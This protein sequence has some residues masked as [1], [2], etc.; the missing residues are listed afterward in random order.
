[1]QQAIEIYAVITFAILGLSHVFQHRA[2]VDFIASYCAL[3]RAGV[4]KYSFLTLIGGSLIVGFHNVWAGI[5]A[6]LTGIG[7]GLGFKSAIAFLF[8]DLAL[9]EMERIQS[10]N[11]QLLLV[12]GILMVVVAIILGQSLWQHATT[13]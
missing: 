5:P 13:T 6:L 2:W 12:P 11:S 3:G 8:P 4:F 10:N 9:R 1:M 7:W